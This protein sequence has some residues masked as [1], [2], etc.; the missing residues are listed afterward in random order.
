MIHSYAHLR[1]LLSTGGY[2]TLALLLE[3]S[4]SHLKFQFRTKSMHQFMNAEMVYMYLVYCAIGG[5]GKTA[6]RLY[7]ERYPNKPLPHHQIFGSLHHNLFEYRTY[8]SSNYYTGQPRTTLIHAL[9]KATLRPM[10]EVSATS[11]CT[12][13]HN[14][15]AS[16]FNVWRTHT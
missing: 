7:V 15:A 10:E 9:E 16:E 4:A 6:A 14:K 12:I 3:C 8:R 11:T 1:A 13:V 2:C 5:N